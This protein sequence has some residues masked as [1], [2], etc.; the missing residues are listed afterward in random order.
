MTHQNG[1]RPH[2]DPR[3]HLPETPEAL[4]AEALAPRPPGGIWL[5]ITGILL[6]LG[7]LGVWMRIAG[8]YQDRAAWGFYAATIG[9]ILST[10]QAAPLLSVATRL[11]KGFWRK[12]LVRAAELFTVSGIINLLLLIPLLPVLP[13]L[14][15]RMTF[16]V[17]WPGAPQLPL[18]LGMI[19]L[20]VCG[21]GLLYTSAR[22]DVATVLDRSGTAL[23]NARL[24]SAWPGSAG[25]LPAGAGARRG[26]LTGPWLGTPHQ[27]KVMS[28]A[29]TYLGIFYLMMLVF[30]QFMVG[31]EL[32]ISLVPGWRDPIFPAFL[33][34]SSIQAGL[35]TLV[36][37]L[38]L[39]RAF[40]GYRRFIALD[41]FWNPAKLM[42]SFSMLWFYFWWSGFIIFWYGRTP[43]EQGVL[44][45]VIFGPYLW[46]FI[47]SFFCNFVIPLFLLIWNPI[48]VSIGGPI[49]AGVIIIFGNLMDRIRIYAG[50]FG[51][52][53]VT[54]H[55][56][57]HTPAT[58]M[59]DLAD[60][61]VFIGAIGGIAFLY[62]LAMRFIPAVSLWELKEGQLLT[63]HR[64]LV[65]SAVVV[66]GKPQ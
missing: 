53:D 51:V 10:A 59:P 6:I 34:I 39:L 11:T 49:L 37:A 4:T 27:W 42:M 54:A 64:S 36:V 52:E 17:A 57:E 55:L 48:R 28:N 35:A 58:R 31:V 61:L 45:T 56:V 38:A 24:G 50:A 5:A 60:I 7:V 16:W 26:L 14:E 2:V 47:A 32:A 19:A 12:P 18:L 40:G 33:A 21:L 20:V 29:I 25:I 66:I 30:M 1:H 43:P 62:L 13:P 3:P 63:R 46:P 8:G 22:P 9:F 15:G 65:R 23:R 41:Q 44:M